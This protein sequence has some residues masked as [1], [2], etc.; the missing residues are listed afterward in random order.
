VSKTSAVIIVTIFLLAVA[1]FSFPDPVENFE[2]NFL[3]SYKQSN[4]VE[5]KRLLEDFIQQQQRAGGFPIRSNNGSVIFFYAGKGIEK[6]VR[7]IGDF[8]SRSFYNVY[9]DETG[10]QMARAFE[11]SPLFYKR[12]TFEKGARIDYK[13]VVDGKRLTD[14]LNPRTV[15]SGIAPAETNESIAIVSELVLPGY[16]LPDALNENPNVAQGKL[17]TVEEPWA[18]PKIRIYLPPDYDSNQKYP[19]IYTADGSAW[20]DFIRLP[21]LL[22]NLMTQKRIKP[23][24]AVMIDSMADRRTWYYYNPQYLTYIKKVV[25][26][27]DANYSTIQ[28]PGARLHAGSSA[29]G[30]ITLYAGFER[31]DLFRKLA[32]L[33]PSLMGPPHY[34]EPYFTG[35]KKLHPELEIWLSAGTY[36][37]YIHQDALTMEAYFKRAG[38]TPRVSITPEGHSFG[39]WR[40]AAQKMLLHFFGL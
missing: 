37:P 16:V 28:D 4:H 19:V 7:I 36:E 38:L 18:M 13:F 2:K 8:R 22:N 5:R 11:N 24:I 30:A 23:V 14:P 1:G 21:A 40:S 20:L 6:E 17:I 34:Y 33:S 35:R 26:Y 10:E 12:M 31:P 25:D 15:V 39:A 32:L 3:N 27:I 29:G 9:W